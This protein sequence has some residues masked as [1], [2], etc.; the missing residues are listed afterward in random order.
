V[1]TVLNVTVASDEVSRSLDTKDIL[2]L[3]TN[4]KAGAHI[5]EE[6]YTCMYVYVHFLHTF[7][8]IKESARSQI[9]GQPYTCMYVCLQTTCK[10][11]KVS[12]GSLSIGIGWLQ[13]VGSLKLQVSFAEY[14]QFYTAHYCKGDR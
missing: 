6:S 1:T 2:F 3:L 14:R 13:L 8:H 9:Y 7:T 11:I 12:E 10:C 5:H 4:E